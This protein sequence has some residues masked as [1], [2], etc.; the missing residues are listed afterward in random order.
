MSLEFLVLLTY[1]AFPAA[2]ETFTD[3]DTKATIVRVT[4]EHDGARCVHAYSTWS[5]MNADDTRLLVACDDV[6]LLYRVD[7]DGVT[8]D[9]KLDARVQLEGAIWS[10]TDP[11]LLYALEAHHGTKL[12]AVDVAHH[13]ERVLHDFAKELPAGS[14]PAQLDASDDATVFTFHDRD[15]T[16]KRDAWAW[17]GK[18]LHKFPRPDGKTVDETKIDPRGL[19]VLVSFSDGSRAFWDLATGD[20]TPFKMSGHYDLGDGFLVGDDG[21]ANG[22][23]L[24]RDGKAPIDLVKWD[25]WTVADHVSVRAGGGGPAIVSTYGSRA[26]LLLVPLDGKPARLL[27]HTFSTAA[28]YWGQPR[29]AI[30]YLG[31]YVVWTSDLGSTGRLDV[32]LL[33]LP[34]SATGRKH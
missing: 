13:R 4:D 24:L 34:A 27:A 3:P 28:D 8:F 23:M 2:G 29:A 17:D 12:V 30:D 6:P 20:V 9:R 10:R 31:R 32:L 19:R 26:D 18:A 11:D 16:G 1:P 5:P 33:K 14:Y 15:D 21:I 22:V 7:R 25:A